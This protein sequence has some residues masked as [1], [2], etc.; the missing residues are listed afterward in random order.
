[1]KM[2]FALLLAT[3]LHAQTNH[4]VIMGGGGEPHK[5]YKGQPNEETIFDRSLEALG[6]YSKNP[7]VKTTIAFN[8][9]HE[10]TEEISRRHFGI[11]KPFDSQEFL[12][13]I[14]QY[15]QKI[16]RGEITNK[17]QILINILSHGAKKSPGELTHQ[18]AA[19]GVVTDFNDMAG[20]SNV[21]VD[22]LKSLVDVATRE[23]VK[24]GIIDYS[25]HS[26][27]T[28]ALA[29]ANTCVIASTGP[30]HFAGAGTY[31]F[32]TVV[33]EALKKGRTLEEAYLEAR[34]R[35]NDVSFPMISSPAGKEVQEKIYTPMTPYLYYHHP[36]QDKFIPFMEEK[37]SAG[38][39][40]CDLDEG[41]STIMKE[42]QSVSRFQIDKES[43]DELREFQKAV[44]EYNSFLKEL[45]EKMRIHGLGEIGKKHKLC[46]G[47][48]CITYST[49]EIA[50]GRY[51]QTIK[52]FESQDPKG[53]KDQI[54]IARQ[55]L[56]L[57]EQI[58]RDSPGVK[59]SARFWSS[60]PDLQRKTSIL[61]SNV[62]KH[63]RTLYQ[64][65]YQQ[66]QASG[67][68]PCRDFKL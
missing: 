39:D 36:N 15:K 4:M 46:S 40:S 2:L 7:H 11:Q 12:R 57:K 41:I 27:N 29:N 61:E 30:D 35:F 8:G 32:G 56:V 42:V 26:G 13:M 51:E 64:L 48:T 34:S 17:D 18:I 58:L 49:K 63:Q 23:G 68:N 33:S 10:K 52:F 25:C 67:P 50:L 44:T 62:G 14:T 65:M 24:L 43:L 59:D 54:N 47:S 1:M 55:A 21:S 38:A 19:N 37:V 9:G 60:F 28:L 31:A 45:K 66:S 20:T 22:A 53:Y 3:S 16:E 6:A 5:N